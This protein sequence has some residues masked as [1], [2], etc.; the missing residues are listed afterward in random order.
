MK[1]VGIV[2]ICFAVWRGRCQEYY[3]W[4]PC[5]SGFSFSNALLDNLSVLASWLYGRE[6]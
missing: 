2:D 6:S 4:R 3:A 1:Y 5:Q